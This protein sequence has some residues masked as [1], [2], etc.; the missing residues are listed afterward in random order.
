MNDS[1]KRKKGKGKKKSFEK[2]VNKSCLL[3]VKRGGI[4]K[5]CVFLNFTITN[6]ELREIVSISSKDHA[7]K[8]S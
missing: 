6:K 4:F 5:Q 2:K 3:P 7:L 8:K 1:E